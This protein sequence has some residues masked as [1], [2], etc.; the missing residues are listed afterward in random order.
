MNNPMLRKLLLAIYVV[1]LVSCNAYPSITQS[2]PIPLPSLTSTDLTFRYNW[3]TN[4]LN[5]ATCTPPCWEGITPGR[6]SLQDT[7]EILA[8]L[9]GAKTMSL[10]KT[11]VQWAGSQSYNGYAETEAG[12]NIILFISIRFNHNQNISLEEA[13]G[14][15]GEPIN[16]QSNNCVHGGCD[17]FMIYPETGL[18]L[19]VVSPSMGYTVEIDKSSEIQGLVFFNPGIDNYLKIVPFQGFE[20]RK[21]EG[22]ETYQE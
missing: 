18:A 19:M 6:T 9:P 1:L 2:T 14:V 8:K 20:V 4:W 21:W 22:Y 3:K 15:F 13:L 11:G 10:T 16:I 17:V 12:N 5:D 7:M